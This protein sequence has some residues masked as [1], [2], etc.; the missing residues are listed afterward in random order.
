MPIRIR[1]VLEPARLRVQRL[2]SDP[3]TRRWGLRLLIAV[4]VY[5][6]L[7]G[8]VAPRL[9]RSTIEQQL[10][11]TLHRA[12]HLDAFTLNPYTLVVEARGLQIEEAA[13]SEPAAAAPAPFLRLE[14]LRLRLSWSSLPR[15]KP[16]I[17]ELLVDGLRVNLERR[18]PEVFNVSDLLTTLAAPADAPAKSSRPLQ[19]AISNIRLEHA[20]IRFDDRVR[21]EQHA[22]EDLRVG[23]PFLANLPSQVDIDV[24]PL[25]EA[26]ID[27]SP[28]SLSG[29]TRPFSARLDSRLRLRFSGLELPKLLAYSPQPLPVRVDRARLS[30]DLELRFARVDSQPQLALS[31]RVDLEDLAVQ[32]PDGAP[33]LEAK[34]IRLVAE[35]VQPLV[36]SAILGELRIE[37]PVLSLSRAADGQLSL[38][39]LGSG[40]AAAAPEPA[41]DAASAREWPAITLRHLGLADGRIRFRDEAIGKTA[42]SYELAA[43]A[44][45]A[46]AISTRDAAPLQAQ[47]SGQLAQGGALRL[48]ASA[49][50]PARR[51]SAE[52]KLDALALSAFQ[53]YLATRLNARL[54]SGMLDAALMLEVDAAEPQTPQLRLRDSRLSLRT[55]KLLPT[56]PGLAPLALAR[57]D[58]EIE[59]VDLARRQAAITALNLDGLALG[60]QR[61]P[62][63]RLDL[64][65]LLPASAAP[66][67]ARRTAPSPAWSWRVASARLTGASLDFTDRAAP[68]PVRLALSELALRLGPLSDDLHRG[69]PLELGGRWLRKGQFSAQGTLT[70]EPL[71]LA[72]TLKASA[73]DLA[74]LSPYLT[75]GINAS[76]G[77]LQASLTGS[78]SLR[79]AASGLEAGYQGE[80]AL[81]NLRVIDPQTLDGFLG[82]G[83]LALARLEAHSGADGT[84]VGIGS[85]ALDRFFA[86]VLLDASGQLNIGRV[87]AAR[88]SPEVAQPAPDAGADAAPRPVPPAAPALQLQ[89]DEIRLGA[90]SLDYT[91]NFI[92]PNFRANLTDIGGRIGRI[93]S[94]QTEDSP[95][96]IRA[97]LNGSG[98]VAISGG[99]NPLAATPALDLTAR[100]SEI[101]LTRFA[102]YSTKYTGYPIVKGK[103]KVDLHYA[104]REGALNANNHI[105]IDQLTFGDRVDSASATNLPV[106]L[107]ISLLKNRRGEID[108]ELPVSGSLSDP[109]FNVGRLV[110]SAFVNLIGKAVTSPFSLLAGAFGG[111]SAADDLGSIAFEPGSAQ[112]AGGEQAKLARIAEALVDKPGVRLEL[113]GRVDA[114]SDAPALRQA[115][116]L[117][118][119]QQQ[120]RKALGSRA[121]ADDELPTIAADEYEKYL[122][123]AYA[124]ADIPKPRNALGIAKTLPAAEMATRLADAATVG[125]AELRAL[126]EAR[127][128]AVQQALSAQVSPG[129][130]F[131]VAPS[132]EAGDGARPGARVDFSVKD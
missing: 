120:K 116:V 104:L 28:F 43:L 55:L 2:A 98:D 99:I 35:D 34:A 22:I 47:L 58:L 24:Q 46:H 57:A 106:R 4:L 96:D 42:A 51:G 49:V 124:A 95:V 14:Q 109:Q 78:A 121:A 21:N 123:R 84:R 71:Q 50:L 54:A 122:A 92:K 29:D 13:G 64:T 86:Q 5:G 19:F 103:L 27:G 119:L 113:I 45:D 48:E 112:L 132:L 79:R 82:F 25:L 102:T 127:A 32:W 16:I 20:Q 38:A 89:V 26:R 67:T 107:A 69:I 80:L 90:G 44:L 70:P 9:L 85:L 117:R 39:R 41:P 53:P 88:A 126:A 130:L 11:Q 125:D 60:L 33:L 97:R 77:S 87:L 23:I 56:L 59:S 37:Q 65:R 12:A 18:A 66:A 75:A 105:F 118:L 129:R 17:A 15:L 6:L 10:A 114:A 30:T 72:A 111:R 8:L 100:A 83:T 76:I 131:L 91:D 52:L 31:G 3:R 36:P 93:A 68:Q 40:A 74:P 108:L 110:W 101:E 128:A 94:A 63:G 61:E 62:D 1:H 81:A 7:G 73:L 115:A